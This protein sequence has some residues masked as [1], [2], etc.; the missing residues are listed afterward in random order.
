MVC[1][2]F[3]EMRERLVKWVSKVFLVFQDPSVLWESKDPLVQLVLLVLSVF[4]GSKERLVPQV[5][6]VP[7]EPLAQLVPL[8]SVERLEVKVLRESKDLLE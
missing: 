3:V 1:K 8:V 6:V 2:A 7:L 5:C 4:V